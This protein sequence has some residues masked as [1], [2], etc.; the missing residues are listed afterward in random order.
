MNVTIIGAGYVGLTTGLALSSVG[1]DVTCVDV[2]PDVVERLQPGTP[3]ILERG[4]PELLAEVKGCTRFQTTI[5]PLKRR[6]RGARRAAAPDRAHQLPAA[7]LALR[8]RLHRRAHQPGVR[9]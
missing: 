5:P 8:H 4:L 9:R 3:T 2:K 7:R 6:G 1:H